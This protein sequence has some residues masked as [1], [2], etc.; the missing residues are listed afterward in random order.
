MFQEKYFSWGDTIGHHKNGTLDGYSFSLDNWSAGLCG[1]GHNL[2][3][4]IPQGNDKYDAAT[5]N[6][7]SPWKMPTKDQCL[8]LK[9]NITPEWITIN[10]VNGY[11][12]ISKS[13]T[14]KYIFI[15]AAGW[16][17]VTTLNDAGSNGSYWST[18]YKYSVN[19]WYMHF[20]STGVKVTSTSAVPT[21]YSIRPVQ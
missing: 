14:N 13:D 16:C 6:M 12:F 21:G 1:S 9:N 8:E 20:T 2:R 15:P 5:A 7:G 11:K 19:A 3:N 17:G 10:G 18:T 4:D